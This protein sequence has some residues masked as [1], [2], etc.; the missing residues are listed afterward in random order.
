MTQLTEHF[1]LEELTFSQAAAR[2]GLSNQPG[3]DELGRLKRTAEGMEQVRDLL[4]VPINVSSGYRSK[5]VNAIIGGVET[6]QHVRGEAVDFTARRFGSVAETVAKIAAS[7]IA[8]DQLI[9][10]YG[11]WVHIS[12]INP[13]ERGRSSRR[14]V[15]KIG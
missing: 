14:Q 9:N 7:D 2:R 13:A 5:A 12:F 8:F 15:L 3:P 6:S 10:E 11:Q 4:G 1:S